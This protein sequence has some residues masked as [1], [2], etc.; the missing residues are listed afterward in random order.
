[1]ANRVLL[2][3][4]KSYG[5]YN[6]GERAYFSQKKANQLT[7]GTTPYAK[8][9]EPDEPEPEPHED[10][11][12]DADVEGAQTLEDLD[13]QILREFAKELGIDHWQLKGHDT[14]VEELENAGFGVDAIKGSQDQ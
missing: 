1:M 12:P 4:R 2:Q 13:T 5:M 7:S 8:I 6:A 3:F 10:D 14:L 11:G 9:V